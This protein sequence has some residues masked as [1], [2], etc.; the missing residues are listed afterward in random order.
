METEAEE[1]KYPEGERTATTVKIAKG[2]AEAINLFLETDKAKRLGYRYK[3]DVVN[4]A[5]RDFLLK[6]GIETLEARFEHFNCYEDH[7]TIWDKKL[8]RLVDVYFSS[9][10][11]YVLCS[12]CEESD[13]EHVQFAL[14]IPKVVQ[15]LKD[16]GWIFKDGRPVRPPF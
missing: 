1:K 13:C 2:L 14:S 3:G 5:V 11:P 12:L 10:Q 7:V 8:R 6:H 9:K 15:T 4:D 16:R